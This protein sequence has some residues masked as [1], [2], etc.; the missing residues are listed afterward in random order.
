MR[1]FVVSRL[2]GR[3]Y[4]VIRSD[5][6]LDTHAADGSSSGSCLEVHG[7]PAAS[8]LSQSVF[9]ATRLYTNLVRLFRGYRAWTWRTCVASCLPLSIVHREHRA[10]QQSV[11]YIS[12]P[13]LPARLPP[14]TLHWRRRGL[15][16]SCSSFSQDADIR[17]DPAGARSDRISGSEGI[18]SA[19]ASGISRMLEG[20][21]GREAMHSG[22]T[23]TTRALVLRKPRNCLITT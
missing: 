6:L 18:R 10:S 12:V 11:G 13:Q 15:R 21:V 20:F 14:Q 5:V 2:G 4:V 7:R 8:R 19:W 22:V 3:D 16:D 23:P 17:D 9:A 1:P